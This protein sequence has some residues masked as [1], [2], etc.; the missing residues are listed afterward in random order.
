VRIQIPSHPRHLSSARDFVFHLAMAEGFSYSDAA[1]IRLAVGEIIYYSIIHSYLGK[2][3]FPVFLEV[4]LFPKKMEIRI[5]DFGKKL[6]EKDISSFDLSDFRVEGLG[7]HI[8]KQVT[9]HF[10]LDS[11]REK[12]NHFV[13]MKLK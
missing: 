5:R 2:N 13:I 7:M 9:D 11:T 4:L 3:D 1:D 12:G 10:Y 6:Q 8:I